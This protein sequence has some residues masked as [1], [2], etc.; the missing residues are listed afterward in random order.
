MDENPRTAWTGTCGFRML[1]TDDFAQGPSTARLTEVAGG[2]A[3]A[4]LCGGVLALAAHRAAFEQRYCTPVLSGGSPAPHPI[5]GIGAGFIPDNLH[6]AILD[7]V[8]QVSQQEA[9]DFARRAAKEEG[10]FVGVSS[11]ASLAAIAKKLPDMPQGSRV[12][13][14]SYDTGERYLSVEGL[15]V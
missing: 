3:L 13:T 2:A 11:G 7:G 6:T 4:L 9:Y 10:L 15:F 8:I 5:Q 12:L 14:F 1:P